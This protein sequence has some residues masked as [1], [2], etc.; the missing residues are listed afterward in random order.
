VVTFI[1]NSSIVAPRPE[2]SPALHQLGL[3]LQLALNEPLQVDLG[4]VKVRCDA[5][6]TVGGTAAEPHV[7]GEMHIVEGTIRYLDRK[8]TVKRAVFRQLDPSHLN[9][10]LDLEAVTAL[11]PT[12]GLRAATEYTITMYITG[13]L[14]EPQVSFSADPTLSQVDIV[15]LLSLGRV[16][17]RDDAALALESSSELATVV[18]DRAKVIAS[19]Q[20]TGYATRRIERFLNLDEVTIDGN[21]FAI[22]SSKGPRL[23]VTKQVRDRLSLSYQ[24]VIGDI[25]TQRLKVSFKLARYLFVEGETDAIDNAGVDLRTKFSF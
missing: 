7:G 1:R 25:G 8:F 23:T 14:D 2:A 3:D 20:I 19:Q 15:S 11:A 16:R 4:I 18:A 17:D 12:I 21:L 6:V 10:S 5:D 9:P 24:S 13:T 22:N